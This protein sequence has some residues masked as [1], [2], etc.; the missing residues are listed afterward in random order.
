MHRFHTHAR[1]VL[2]DSGAQGSGPLPEALDAQAEAA[3]EAGVAPLT[4]LRQADE[5]SKMEKNNLKALANTLQLVLQFHPR[6]LCG[7]GIVIP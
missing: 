2:Q 6:R 3:E 5:Q 1:S 7:L 4:G